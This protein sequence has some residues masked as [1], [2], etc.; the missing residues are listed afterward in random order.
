MQ[1]EFKNCFASEGA[2]INQRWAL[3][4]VYQKFCRYSFGLPT[5]LL[6]YLVCFE[7]EEEAEKIRYLL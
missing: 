6:L 7:I 1:K 3:L 5:L 2:S 4:L